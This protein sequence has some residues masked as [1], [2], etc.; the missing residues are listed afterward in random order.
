[1]QHGCPSKPGKLTNIRQDRRNH[2]GWP[3]NTRR[4]FPTTIPRRWSW[5]HSLNIRTR[6]TQQLYRDVDQAQLNFQKGCC[7]VNR[8]G[9]GWEG[10]QLKEARP[11]WRRRDQTFCIDP[12][13]QRLPEIPIP[14]IPLWNC[15]ID[16]PE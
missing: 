6:D 15:S 7:F 14:E 16:V 2:V 4:P 11:K 3:D 13:T 1:V 12:R 9:G 5:L 10:G 8:E